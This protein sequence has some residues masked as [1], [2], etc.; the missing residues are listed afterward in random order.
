VCDSV[1]PSL[2]NGENAF[3]AVC[4]VS[5]E[6]AVHAATTDAVAALGG[7]DGVVAAAGIAS[8]GA[9]HELTLHDWGLVIGVNGTGVFLTGVFLNDAS[10]M[11]GSSVMVD[12]GYTA[13]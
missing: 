5:S 6:D 12:G 1:Q 2:A 9:I 11:T 10:F 4:D 3:G 13:I 8:G 7:L